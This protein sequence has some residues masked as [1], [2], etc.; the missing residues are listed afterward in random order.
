MEPHQSLLDYI[1]DAWEEWR[2]TSIRRGSR[3]L[4]LFTPDVPPWSTI[5]DSWTSTVLV[6]SQAGDRLSGV[7]EDTLFAVFL[8]SWF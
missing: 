3:Y 4:L 2:D 1:T 8:N 7:M 5:A 6:P